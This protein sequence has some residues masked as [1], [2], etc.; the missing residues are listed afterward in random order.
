LVEDKS[1]II[2]DAVGTTRLE[3]LS[4]R[5]DLPVFPYLAG[6]SKWQASLMIPLM[7]EN[8]TAKP[9]LRLESNLVGTAVQYPQPLAKSVEDERSLAMV[10]EFGEEGSVWHL[11][12]GDEILAGVFELASNNGHSE[13]KRGE[14][15]LGAAA[16]LPEDEGLRIAGKVQHF[17]SDAWWPVIFADEKNN[18]ESLVNRVDMVFGSAE[19]FDQTF[20]DV[21][22]NA[23]HFPGVWSADVKSKELGGNIR[24]PDMPEQV[25]EMDLS[26][27]HLSR[28]EE[29]DDGEMLD[30][31]ELP[32]FNVKSSVASYDGINLGSVELITTQSANGLTVESLKLKSDIAEVDLKGAWTQVDKQQ[33][34][35]LD[36]GLRIY[37][38]GSVL[39][40]LGYAETIKNG[41]GTGQ[42][43]LYWQG[44]IFDPLLETVK[45]SLSFDL[46]DGRLLEVDPGAGRLFGLM[47]V[48]ALPRRLILDFSDFFGEGLT[49]DYM[50]GK[51]DF[52]EGNAFT[53]N[54]N[55]DGPSAKIELK[56][57][58]GLVARDYDQQVRVVPHVTSG[59]PLVG[60]V[61]GGVG[62]GAVVYLVERLFKRG[63][64]KAT[65]IHY[66]ISGDWD[67][68]V[69]KQIIDKP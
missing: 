49:F 41:E 48:Q 7:N 37:D 31:R 32:P 29:E 40:E 10:A 27:F 39:S 46:N 63:I 28:P 38:M 69:I 33:S 16:Q 14:L 25:V 57:R 1:N 67:E 55:L 17:D 44:S 36:S 11:G 47:S 8:R 3:A 20:H 61:A 4:Q 42:V 6:Q 53:D 5:V 18:K 13:L 26:H 56:G 50:R 15:H 54:F 2:F 59:L 21:E 65:E 51:F 58:V 23:I 60:A 43:N 35:V 52:K 24:L 68:P 12:Y 34:A 66:Q 22:L 45:G 19:L 30:P 9:T 62:V 64:D